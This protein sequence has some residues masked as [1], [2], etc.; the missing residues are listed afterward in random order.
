[1]PNKLHVAP[2]LLLCCAFVL[3][4]TVASPKRCFTIQV[5]A[6]PGEAEAQER[7]NFF[8]SRDFSPVF[9]KHVEPYY[10]VF[11]GKFDY[12][13]DALV[14]KKMLRAGDCPDA[15]EKSFDQ[16]DLAAITTPN[17]APFAPVFS[18]PYN[19]VTSL[20]EYQISETEPPVSTITSLIA[21]TSCTAA[22]AALEQ[23][24]ASRFPTD[25]I[26]GWATLTLGRLHLRADEQADAAALFEQ[27]A[28]AQ[29]AAR[30]QD[31]RDALF[32]L[33]WIDHDR[34]EQIKA[35]RGLDEVARLSADAKT[36]ARCRVE[37]I[38]IIFEM[39]RS[40]IGQL[41]EVRRAADEFLASTP[42]EFR[43]YRATAELMSLETYF[44]DANYEKLI[45][46]ATQYIEKYPDIKREHAMALIWIGVGYAYLG[47]YESAVPWFEGVLQMD[48]DP[49]KD[50]F[51][52]LD[53]ERFSSMWLTYLYGMIGY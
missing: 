50:N 31:V 44:Y 10:K 25:P 6:Y 45:D 4:P 53:F 47:D 29:V 13:M 7:L 30:R 12:H 20:P 19:S 16:V 49:N 40:G 14:W 23:E 38:A 1:M 17:G 27:V 9:I 35:Y 11:V 48:L 8:V 2:F 15:F 5:G 43:D 46:L 18:L 28:T 33:S 51:R 41:E 32:A 21:G 39:A 52:A 37:Q 26:R 22:R 36:S 3:L 24:I 34:R 42:I